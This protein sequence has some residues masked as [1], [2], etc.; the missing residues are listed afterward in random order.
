VLARVKEY[1]QVREN[2]P[3][4]LVPTKVTVDILKEAGYW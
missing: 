3:R 2:S 1:V 4:R